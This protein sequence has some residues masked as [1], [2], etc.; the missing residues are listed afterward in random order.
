MEKRI[1]ILSDKMKANDKLFYKMQKEQEEY[2][3][4]LRKLLPEELIN[5]SYE[6]ST[7]NQMLRFMETHDLS[8]VAAVGLLRVETPLA[9]LFTAYTIPCMDY[10]GDFSTLM[11]RGG[12][13]L[14]KGLIKEKE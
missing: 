4:R 12:R 6:I 9:Y 5:L 2:L 13:M 3:K 7:R 10:E 8:I 1:H 14:Y 11:E